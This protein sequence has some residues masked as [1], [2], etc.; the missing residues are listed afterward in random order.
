MLRL[1][2]SEGSDDE[3]QQKRKIRKQVTSA[4]QQNQSS[5]VVTVQPVAEEMTN[6]LYSMYTSYIGY[7]FGSGAKK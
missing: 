3:S 6:E 4:K 2:G 7:F 5:R 1:V